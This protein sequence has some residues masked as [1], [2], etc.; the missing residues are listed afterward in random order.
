MTVL[1]EADAIALRG[2]CGVEEAE[3]L[4]ALIQQYPGYAVDLSQTGQVHTALWQIIMALQP[5]LKGEPA[6]N[7]ARTWLMP[8]LKPPASR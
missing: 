8:A 7:F 6:S 1:L 4:L 2:A 5:P 3:T